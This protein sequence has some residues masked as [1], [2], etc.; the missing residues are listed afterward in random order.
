MLSPEKD[1]AILLSSISCALQTS[2]YAMKRW[3]ASYR[4]AL[5]TAQVALAT[6]LAKWNPR[7]LRK[8]Y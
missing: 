2:V 3:R 5:L 7:D 1:S 6:Y 8:A 4:L